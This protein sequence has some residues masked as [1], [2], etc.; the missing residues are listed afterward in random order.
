MDATELATRTGSTPEGIERLIGLAI[1]EPSSDG[2]FSDRDITRVALALAIEESGISLDDVGR[3][4]GEGTLSFEF[5]EFATTAPVGLLDKTL[6]QLTEEMGLQPGVATRF[7]ASMGLP[8]HG[9]DEP[10][11]EDVAELLAIGAQAMAAGLPEETLIRTFR[12][13]TQNLQ[14]IA[15]YQNELFVRDIMGRMLASGHDPA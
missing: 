9:P 7:Q 11:R 13:F 10:V 4:I 12:I 3:A 14:R 8:P 6:G 15:E 5:A 1:L 2:S